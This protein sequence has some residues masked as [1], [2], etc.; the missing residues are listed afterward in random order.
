MT[1]RVRITVYAHIDD[2]AIRAAADGA[3]PAD[4]DKAIADA[5]AASAPRFGRSTA[6]LAKSWCATAPAAT[7]CKTPPAAPVP[8]SGAGGPSTAQRT[9]PPPSPAQSI[10]ERRPG[11]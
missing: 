4:R 1:R 7:S 3:P 5:L 2:A 6:P 9:H 10:S 8:S 11:L